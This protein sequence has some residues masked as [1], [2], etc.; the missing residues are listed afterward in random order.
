MWVVKD[1]KCNDKQGLMLYDFETANCTWIIPA[2]L[3]I[4]MYPI[5][6][7]VDSIAAVRENENEINEKR[8]NSCDYTDDTHI[9]V[10]FSEN[11]RI[12]TNCIILLFVVFLLVIL[13]LFCFYLFSHSF[14]NLS[15][16]TYDILSISEWC[17]VE[18]NTYNIVFSWFCCS[19]LILRSVF[20]TALLDDCYAT[21]LLIFLFIF[22]YYIFFDCGCLPACIYRWK[23]VYVL[24]QLSNCNDFSSNNK[25]STIPECACH[26]RSIKSV[27]IQSGS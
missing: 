2:T 4:R 17:V 18:C 25:I 20:C 19:K 23:W 11:P 16:F 24:F 7:W 14:L 22:Y 21:L 1:W 9:N 3:C 26:L 8:E 13:S 15:Q 5:G 12:Q 6:V 10:M 27:Y